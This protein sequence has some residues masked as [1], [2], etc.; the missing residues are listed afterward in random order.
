MF[1]VHVYFDVGPCKVGAPWRC[2]YAT[3]PEYM[4]YV[5]T[6]F[7]CICVG[8]HFH[9]CVRQIIESPYMGVQAPHLGPAST[10]HMYKLRHTW[11]FA[12]VLARKRHTQTHTCGQC[13][14][15]LLQHNNLGITVG[16]LP[17]NFEIGCTDSHAPNR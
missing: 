1:H 17:Y 14:R 13:I 7:F 15:G 16:I 9:G 11:T 12:N 2:M 10:Q 5:Y 8:V 4:F 3:M 6:C